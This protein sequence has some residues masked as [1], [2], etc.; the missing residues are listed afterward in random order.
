MA[1]GSSQTQGLDYNETFNPVIKPATI[2]IVL[3]IAVSRGWLVKQLDVN[4][5]FLNGSLTETVY[6]HQPPV[7]EIQSGDTPLVCKLHKAIYGLK[8]A[9]R[10]WF[11]KLRNSL[12]DLGFTNPPTLSL[13]G[14]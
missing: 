2:R 12:H 8:Q 1:K 5:V 3:T 4:N 9:P 13:E 6:M 7:Y 14:C 10:A 11:D